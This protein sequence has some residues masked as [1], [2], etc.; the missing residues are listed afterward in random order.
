MHKT[1]NIKRAV[2]L[3]FSSLLKHSFFIFEHFC[4]FSLNNSR[5]TLF[6][7]AMDPDPHSF[8]LLGPDPG[9]ENL[10]EKTE[11]IQGKWKKIVILK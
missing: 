5:S 4:I 9:G 8:S 2:C 6:T 11:K 1:N 3:F 7:G 10:R